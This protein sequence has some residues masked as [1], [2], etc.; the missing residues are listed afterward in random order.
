MNMAKTICR[1]AEKRIFGKTMVAFLLLCAWSASAQAGQ[2]VAA[3]A[4]GYV[5]WT[6]SGNGSVGRGT[7]AGTHVSEAFISLEVR[8]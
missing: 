2:S 5:Y 3:K 7:T 4:K 1:A 6:N 8:G